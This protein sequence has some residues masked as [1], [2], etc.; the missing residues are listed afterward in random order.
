MRIVC[1]LALQVLSLFP[2]MSQSMD[3][4]ARFMTTTIFTKGLAWNLLSSGMRNV[5]AIGMYVK[6]NRKENKTDM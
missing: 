6:K 4:K 2:E 3:M 5:G 1:F